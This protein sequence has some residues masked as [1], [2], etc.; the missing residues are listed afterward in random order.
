MGFLAH[1]DLTLTFILSFRLLIF[2]LFDY[3]VH[4]YRNV[5]SVTPRFKIKL[6][7]KMLKAIHAQESKTAAREKAQM[8]VGELCAMKLKEGAK[9]V[10]DGI[11]ETLTYCDFPSEHWARIRTNKVVE[12]LNR[13]I[14]RRT[15]V[16]GYHGK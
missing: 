11:K 15:R 12:R 6:V 13:E 3:T 16:V 4:F 10:E 5:F 7:T 14:R 2:N 1:V 9:K 8:V